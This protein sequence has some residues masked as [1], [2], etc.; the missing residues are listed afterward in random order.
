MPSIA[1]LA[2]KYLRNA[3][4]AKRSPRTPSRISE[5]GKGGS[6]NERDGKRKKVVGKGEKGRE[7]KERGVE[8]HER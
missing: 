6:G 2:S 3:L 8:D 1:F 7:G 4:A 5:E